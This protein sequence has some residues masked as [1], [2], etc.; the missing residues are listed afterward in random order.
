MPVIGNLQSCHLRVLLPLGLAAFCLVL[1]GVS[2]ADGTNGARPVVSVQTARNATMCGSQS[3]AFAVQRTGGTGQTLLVN[4]RI[5]GTATNGVDYQRLSGTATIPAGQSSA[6]IGVMPI[7]NLA[8]G[9]NENVT[10]TLVPQN[11]PFTI[12]ALPDSQYYTA[13]IH[14]S[15]RDIF[16]SQTQWIVNHKDDS[17]IVFVLHEGDITDGNSA[18]EWTN[19]TTSISLL[20]GVVPYALAVG[21]HDGLMGE[22]RSDR[23][24][25]P[26]FPREPVPES[27][28][29]WR[30]V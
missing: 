13:E 19:A 23:A 16:T 22:P 24:F 1:P 17:N 3:G 7:N 12:V 8:E 5:S 4:Y 27:P 21:N 2:E 30:G 10:V 9:S 20:D 25:Q 14:G 15:T 28:D 6:M 18:P 26:V 11:Q 29:V